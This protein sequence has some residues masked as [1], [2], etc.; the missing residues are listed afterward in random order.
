VRAQ[1]TALFRPGP[2]MVRLRRG[3]SHQP[4]RRQP[5]A[6]ARIRVAGRPV[7]RRPSRTS[8]RTSS[9]RP[10]GADCL[11]PLGETRV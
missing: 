7:P 10:G 8:S 1:A 11:A 3:G 6:S 2:V 9:G 4:G 5:T